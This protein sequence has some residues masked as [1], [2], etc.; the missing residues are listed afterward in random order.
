M[1][2]LAPICR[3]KSRALLR[4]G[5]CETGEAIVNVDNLWAA[6]RTGA[7]DSR[8]R[9]SGARGESW[10]LPAF[11]TARMDC[12]VLWGEEASSRGRIRIDGQDVTGR[13][14]M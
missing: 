13:R 11:A 2:D 4:Q 6:D 10:A 9:F 8:H 1:E 14:Q 3:E 12:D 5:Q 7:G